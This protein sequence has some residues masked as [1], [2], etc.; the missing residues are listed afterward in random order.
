[1]DPKAKKT[2]DA[3]G[4]AVVNEVYDRSCDFVQTTISR[5]MRGNKPDPLHVAYQKLDPATAAFV[6]Q[7]LLM[8]VDQTFAQF[9]AF[10][11]SHQIPIKFPPD[12]KN[13]KNITALS[14]GLAAEPYNEQGWIARFSKFKDGIPGT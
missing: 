12:E 4:K 2:L 3:F 8:A 6:R 1:M 7:F 9:L 5:G 11:D 13:A 14:D 10:I